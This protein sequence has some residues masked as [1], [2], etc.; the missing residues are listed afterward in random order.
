MTRLVASGWSVTS[1]IRDGE[2]LF[3]VETVEADGRR[4][5][6]GSYGSGDCRSIAEVKALIGDVAFASLIPAGR[7]PA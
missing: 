6:P 2:P 3:V 5:L 4:Y 7:R 1:I